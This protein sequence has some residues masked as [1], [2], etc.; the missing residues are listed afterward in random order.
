MKT[1]A[2]TFIVIALLAPTLA[3]AHGGGCRASERPE[4]CCHRDNSTG[5]DHCHTRPGGYPIS[6]S[7][8]SGSGGDVIIPVMVAGLGIWALS[9]SDENSF[10][11]FK[12]FKADSNMYGQARHWIGV[13][14]D[15]SQN[16]KISLGSFWFVH[17]DVASIL[18]SAEN[19]GSELVLAL[20]DRQSAKSEMALS[21]SAFFNEQS[22][23][24]NDSLHVA[25]DHFGVWDE[26]A[27][28]T[29][30]KAF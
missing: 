26:R 16:F 6:T 22:A 30:C 11:S 14:H 17:D 15:V 13:E 20:G 29:W 9:G 2:A 21:I 23:N 25:T 12:T 19:I 10:I 1:L 4:R 5:G 7:S 28:L 3:L 18:P 24:L 27:T 8:S